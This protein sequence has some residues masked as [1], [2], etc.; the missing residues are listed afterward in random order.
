MSRAEWLPGVG[1]RAMAADDL[2]VRALYLAGA[3][4]MDRQ[5]P[6]EFVQHHVMVPP[7]VIFE[8]R[9]AGVAAVGS[10]LDV[11]GLTARRGLVAAAGV[12]A[13][14]IPQRDQ[15]PQVEG[16][17]VGLADVQGE[18]GSGEGFAEQVAAEE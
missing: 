4:G 2:P 3:V 7:T 10:V 1:R 14:L 15:P 17:V 11:V 6:A 12:L 13:V 8:V 5:S 16:D 9:E 18:G